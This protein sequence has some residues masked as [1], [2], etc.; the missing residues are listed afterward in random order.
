MNQKGG[1]GKTT[2]A[3]NLG[4]YL[5]LKGRKVLLIDMDPQANASCGVGIDF[6]NMELTIYD[7]LIQD[8]ELINIIHPT[9]FA[10]LHIAPSSPDLA[11][12][13]IELVSNVSRETKLKQILSA[14]DSPYEYIIIDCPPSLG[15][16]TINGLVASE[17]LIIPLQCEYFALEGLGH[18][19]QTVELL[20]ENFNPDLKI[21]GI[22]HTMFDK[23]TTLSQE[24]V[25]EVKNHFDG[26]VF[27]TMIPR[28]VRLGEAPSHGLPIALYS[29][30]SSGA[31]A[32]EKFTEELI[33]LLEPIENPDLKIVSRETMTTRSA[34]NG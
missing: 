28:S 34:G 30:D 24:V 7:A 15:L 31:L 22:L 29:P 19:L 33:N 27:K 32:Y 11:G 18:L 21:L 8:E 17:S 6:K 26:H 9:S 10:N 20:K 13:E 2:T 25:A 1:V 14:Y 12:A 23:R 4:S 3:V 16:L 5:A